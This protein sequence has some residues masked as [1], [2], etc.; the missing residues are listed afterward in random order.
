MSSLRAPRSSS[1]ANLATKAC[2]AG[3]AGA[4]EAAI[5]AG[6]L[7]QILLVV[8]LG[9]IEWRLGGDLRRN[10]P[11]PRLRQRLLILLARCFGGLLLR[12]RSEERRVGK[13]W[14]GRWWRGQCMSR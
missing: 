10:L 9:V 13:E 6:I 5:P 8:V 3:H 12:L 11:V 2:G 14:R 7:R 1:C 4:T